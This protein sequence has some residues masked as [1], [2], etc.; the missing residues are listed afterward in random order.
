MI[1]TALYVLMFLCV[2]FGAFAQGETTD[3][4]DFQLRNETTLIIPVFD[5][6]D[7]KKIDKFSL[8][9]QGNLRFGQNRLYPMDRRIGG[10]FEIQVN[11]FLSIS[12][13]YIYRYGEEVRDRGSFEH[14]ARLDVSLEKKWRSFS[15]KDRNRLEYRIR[16]GADNDLRYRNRITLKIPVKEDNKKLIPFVANEFFYSRNDRGWT[17][18]EFSTGIESRL[19]KRVTAEFFYLLKT[20]DTGTIR[21]INSINVNLKITLDKIFKK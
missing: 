1:R 9:L 12:P 21:R 15:I 4:T 7:N 14:R 19:S 8:I 2:T 13:T 16:N 6:E 5:E 10:G 3:D 17:S 11:K 18:N 20:N